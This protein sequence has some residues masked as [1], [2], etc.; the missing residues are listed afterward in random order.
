ML[1]FGSCGV[2]ESGVSRLDSARLSMAVMERS[3][4]VRCGLVR[5]VEFR[6]FWNVLVRRVRVSYGKFR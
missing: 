6:Q 2:S 3:V 1:S 5:C 4:K